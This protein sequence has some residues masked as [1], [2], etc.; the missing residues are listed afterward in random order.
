LGQQRLVGLRQLRGQCG[1]HRRRVGRVEFRN[2][3]DDLGG[4]C[5]ALLPQFKFLIASISATGPRLSA[6]ELMLLAAR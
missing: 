2:R 6:F 3:G 5:R 4:G 1:K